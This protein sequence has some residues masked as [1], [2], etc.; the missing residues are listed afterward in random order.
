MLLKNNQMTSPPI[1]KDIAHCFVEEVTKSVTQEINNDVF[2]L[3][4]DE[5]ADVSDKEQMD[6]VFRFIDKFGLVKESFVGISHV[7]D[8]SS[9]T[10]KYAIDALFAKHGLCLKKVRGKVMM[11]KAI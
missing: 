5:S 9:L 11:G 2:G 1:Q 3:L 8:T 6:V 4:V 7:K 10:L